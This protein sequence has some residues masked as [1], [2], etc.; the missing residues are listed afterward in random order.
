MKQLTRI[1]TNEDITKYDAMVEM[2][3]R[4]YV[5]KNWNEAQIDRTGDVSLGNSGLTVNDIR[6]QLKMEVCI[7]LH[8]YDPNYRTKDDKPVK[9]STF[10]HKH[11]WHRIGQ[12]MKKHTRKSYG[13]GVWHHNLEETLWETD[14]D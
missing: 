5:L 4:D 7:A 8:N 3:I 14:R 1:L 2:F 12:M 10:V 13:Y 11:L 6:Q 9:E